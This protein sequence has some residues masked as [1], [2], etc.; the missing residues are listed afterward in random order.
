MKKRN[1]YISPIVE[2]MTISSHVMDHALAGSGSHGQ[3]AAPLRRAQ[4]F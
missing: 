1:L 4:V 3:T 2:I